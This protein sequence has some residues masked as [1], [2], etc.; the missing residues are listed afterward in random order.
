MQ[1]HSIEAVQAAEAVLRERQ[2]AGL[3]SSQ[4]DTPVTAAEAS[5]LDSL[6]DELSSFFIATSQQALMEEREAKEELSKLERSF[7]TLCD[8]LNKEQRP[9]SFREIA[10]RQDMLSN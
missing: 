4:S 5:T 10:G 9:P 8:T 3:D 6:P 1:S 2:I 7:R